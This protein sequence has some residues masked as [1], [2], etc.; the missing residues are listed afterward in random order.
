MRAQ[1]TVG[2]LARTADDLQLL[3][4]VIRNSAASTTGHGALAT[5][6]SCAAP[7]NSSLNSLRGVRLG[8]PSTFGWVTSGIS[9]EV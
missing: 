6:V 2:A 3:D 4:S 5:N 9:E 1:D 8:L 7:R